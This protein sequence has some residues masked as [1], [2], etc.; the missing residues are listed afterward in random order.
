MS[1]VGMGVLGAAI[2]APFVAEGLRQPMSRKV[3]AT[4]PGNIAELPSGRTHYRWTG[5]KGGPLA[6]CIHGLSSPHYIFAA[7]ARSLAALGYRV[8]VYDL[9]GRGFSSTPRG[10]QDVDYFLTQLRDLLDFFG[11]DGPVTIVGYSMG[12]ALATAF[13]AEEGMRIKGLVLMASAGLLPVYATPRDRVWTLPVVGDWLTAVAGGWSL[14]RELAGESVAPTVIPDLTS[15]LA[16]ETR[17]RGYLPSLLS[18]RRHVLAQTMDD[19]HRAIADYRIPVLGI[20][21]REDGVIPLAAMGRLA[22]LNPDAHHVELARATHNFP[23]THPTKVG[24][25]LKAFLGD[26]SS[27]TRG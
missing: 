11:I 25:A 23:Q 20:W 21:G 7:T 10:R 8:L 26:Q 24:E 3:Q 4:A 16:A 13:A 27:V 1:V 12:G 2:A 5:P 6:I 9:Y 18:S 22:E 14:R 15:K 19:D 17:R